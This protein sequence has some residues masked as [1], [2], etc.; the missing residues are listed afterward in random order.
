MLECRILFHNPSHI[1]T[2]PKHKD[3]VLTPGQFQ[4]AYI[5]LGSNAIKVFSSKD[6]TEEYCSVTPV[7]MN[8]ELDRNSQYYLF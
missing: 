3:T 2:N 5:E 1:T 4:P 8:V 7:R 6:S